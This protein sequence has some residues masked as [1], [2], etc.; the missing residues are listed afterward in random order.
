M[1]YPKALTRV[2]KSGYNGH[3][4][5]SS[6]SHTPPTG[7]MELSHCKNFDKGSAPPFLGFGSVGETSA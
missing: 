1:L 6:T 7:R 2:S 4:N 5:P 3:P